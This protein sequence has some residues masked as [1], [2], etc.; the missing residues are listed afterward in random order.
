MVK[1]SGNKRLPGRRLNI[2]EFGERC[3]T[4]S[5]ILGFGRPRG[6]KQKTEVSR[7]SGSQSSAV[8]ASCRRAGATRARICGRRICRAGQFCTTP[9]AR[10]NGSISRK[11]EQSR[12]WSISPRGEIIET[13]LIGLDGVVGGHDALRRP[14]RSTAP[15]CR[16]KARRWRSKPTRCGGFAPRAPG[17][18]SCSIR[19][20]RFI[21]AQ[22]QQT[23]ACNVAHSLDARLAR[24]LLRAQDLCGSNFMLTQEALAAFLGVRRTS[25]SLTA[26]AF[27]DEGVIRYR[28][29]EIEIVDPEAARSRVRMSHHARRTSRAS[30]GGARGEGGRVACV[31]ILSWPEVVVRSVPVGL[32]LRR[33]A[34]VFERTPCKPVGIA[35]ASSGAKDNALCDE[36]LNHGR[37]TGSASPCAFKN[38]ARAS[39]QC[40]EQLT[41]RPPERPSALHAASATRPVAPRFAPS[42]RAEH[43]ARRARCVPFPGTPRHASGIRMLSSSARTDMGSTPGLCIGAT[44]E[45]MSYD[46]PSTSGPTPRRW[47]SASGSCKS[48]EASSLC[49]SINS[50]MSSSISSPGCTVV[51]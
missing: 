2:H 32:G 40:R 16:S 46:I 49:A 31:R 26:H 1:S 51:Q 30:V 36:L 14:P 41:R 29:G 18:T 9:A 13:A 37:L 20:E 12:W 10:S 6:K 23:A 45:S 35:Y 24:W 43:G 7:V 17:S 11:G 34:K 3:G 50:R 28:R 22:A 21:Y 48:S 5:G 39:R 15:W 47:K 19:Y 44:L 42:V 4:N 33:D 25:V 27:Q 38:R 8:V